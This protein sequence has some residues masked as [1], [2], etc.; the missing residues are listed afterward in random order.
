MAHQVTIVPAVNRETGETV[1]ID[2]TP[3]WSQDNRQDTAQQQ[4][5][6]EGNAKY[7]P[8][9]RPVG[10]PCSEIP[11]GFAPPRGW[12]GCSHGFSAPH[13]VWPTPP[14]VAAPPP[15]LKEKKR[16][17]PKGSKNKVSRQRVLPVV[18]EDDVINEGSS[19][20]A[21]KQVAAQAGLTV[22]QLSAILA[23]AGKK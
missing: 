15:P 20:D 19:D 17:R 18:T 21:L 16:G 6:T 5:V 1:T 12:R 13:L 4:A 7:I 3:G 8:D 22:E 9:T 14:I 2:L 23:V 10:R 11:A